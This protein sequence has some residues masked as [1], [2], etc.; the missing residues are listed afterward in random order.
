M[1]FAICPACQRRVSLP[2]NTSGRTVNT[3]CPKCGELLPVPPSPTRHHQE[4]LAASILG[5]GGTATLSAQQLREQLAEATASSKN[6]G[7]VAL[8]LGLVG[9]LLL[10]VSFCF[11]PVAWMG[12]VIGGIG[13]LLGLYGLAR[14]LGR[15]GRDVLYIVAGIGVSALAVGL[16]VIWLYSRSQP[17]QPTEETQE[18]EPGIYELG[19]KQLK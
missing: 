18:R 1:H 12:I 2:E 13:L 17:V 14:G 11:W 3:M 8:T 19:K 5:G 6:L 9:L 15:R 10:A 4:E 7:L 16:I